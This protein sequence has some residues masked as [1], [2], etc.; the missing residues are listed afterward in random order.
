MW[1]ANC[2]WAA[3]KGSRRAFFRQVFF[4]L[5]HHHHFLLSSS[6]ARLAVSI[7]LASLLASTLAISNVQAPSSPTAAKNTTI[8]WSSDSSDSNPVTLALF[9][10]DSPD[11]T[12]PGG[13]A[14][15]NNVNPKDN[16]ITVLWP[17][18]EPGS[19]IVSFLSSSNTSDVLASSSSFS[20]SPSPAVSSTTHGSTASGGPS[21][22][23]SAVASSLSGAASSISSVASSALRSLSSAASS[24]ASQH[25]SAASS[26]ASGSTS[27]SGSGNAAV[28]VRLFG[29][30]VG[31]ALGTV[32]A[33]L[34]IG[35][36]VV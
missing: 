28:P 6:M 36:F 33:G 25:S 18:I 29:P 1:E 35:I 17:A 23:H 19:Y 22:S 4:S 14:L 26:A 10:A 27:P 34:A 13:L 32:L 16:S 21:A 20:V 8:T 5:N 24:Q 15:V 11:V 12:Y 7:L 2:G 3:G 30:G 31:A 9:S